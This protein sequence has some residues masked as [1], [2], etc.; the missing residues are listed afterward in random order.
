[1]LQREFAKTIAMSLTISGYLRPAMEFLLAPPAYW[2]V[3]RD[4]HKWVPVLVGW[5]CKAAAMSLAWRVQRVLTATTSAITGGLM[6]ARALLR[7]W[8]KQ[9]HNEK[10][11]SPD[12]RT[13][14]A[15]T[16]IRKNHR[17]TF[18]DEIIGLLIGGIGLY[19]Q[20]GHGFDFKVPFPLSLVSWP[21]DL[22]EHW[23][24][25]QITKDSNRPPDAQYYLNSGKTVSDSPD[26]LSHWKNIAI[27]NFASYAL[28]RG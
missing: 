28:C 14:T 18:L 22:A 13:R 23:I 3:P 15:S 4:F 20:I 24:Q 10:K 9:F 2:C 27:G 26:R 1:M 6:F 7:M 8:H 5:I 17:E 12:K 25:W 16:V 11:G 19:T 21:F